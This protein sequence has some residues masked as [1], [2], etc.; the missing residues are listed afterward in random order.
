MLAR[1]GKQWLGPCCD[2]AVLCADVQA[3]VAT[4]VPGMI[5]E[6]S[7]VA[8]AF[9]DPFRVPDAPSFSWTAQY[10]IL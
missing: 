6:V 10:S 4:D 9:Y 1:S 5:S 7:R 8:E 3:G 2:G